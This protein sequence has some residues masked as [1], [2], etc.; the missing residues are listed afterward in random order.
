MSIMD[1]SKEL[2]KLLGGEKNIISLVHCATRLRFQL[3]DDDQADMEAINNLRFVLSV[4][5][6][7]GQF[8]V[9]IGPAVSK[10]YQAI[11]DQIDIKKS[12]EA[13]KKVKKGGLVDFVLRCISG[14]VTP[15]LPAICGSALIRAILSA[16]VNFGILGETDSTTM[17][18]TAAANAV[19][20][21]L[22]ILI[23]FTLSQQLKVNPYVGAVLGAAL[24]D[25]NFQGLIGQKGTTFLG[26]P[27]EAVDY[28]TSLLPI[29]IIIL[30]YAY[31]DKFLRKYIPDGVAMFAVPFFE[32]IILVPLGV[33]VFGPFGT[34]VSNYLAGGVSYLFN[35]NTA[36]AGGILGMLYQIMVLFGV[37]WG[38]APLCFDSLARTGL[39]PYEGTGG[40][41]SNFGCAGIA[42]GAYLK[43][44]KNSKM[45]AVS[46]SCLSSQLLAGVGEPTLYGIVLKHKRLIPTTMIAGGI[47]GFIAGLFN[48]AENAYVLHNVFSVAFMSYTPMHG[49]LISIITA[50][51]IATVLTYFW[52]IPEGEM[53]DYRAQ[54]ADLAVAEE[55]PVLD[56]NAQPSAFKSLAVYAPL[57]GEV[58]DLN[59]VE[60]DL[61]SN[62]IL[63]EGCAI[64]P[65]HN[66]I[67][68]PCDGKIVALYP[69]KH[70]IGIQ[71]ENGSEILIHIGLNT[72][73]NEGEGFKEFV[74]VG[75]QI[76]KGDKLIEFDKEKLENK[77]Y[78]LVTPIIVTNRD[79]YGKLTLTANGAVN[80]GDAIFGI[81]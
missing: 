28:G 66:V 13:N 2:I 58:I 29:F 59:D 67:T 69:S 10:Y 47:G 9:V 39:D 75:D 44:E 46:I 15:I 48:T 45:K 62:R 41:A 57:K 21:F 26:I 30:I 38:L 54:T 77:G 19:F 60:D 37:H 20:Y 11:N 33:I 63:G 16:L 35:L 31:F 50:F 70:A 71:A 72:V 7:G 65:H 34:T 51:T 6:K 64:I 53:E 25:P 27:V 5:N 74:K 49:I 52:A 79:S 68:A 32:F 43:A 73:M 22:P 42:F 40:I 17:I 76:H 4:V 81:E 18:L 24:L 14:S 23:G 8:Q 1:E 3:N 12:K 55:L 61:F 36:I 78:D 56:G 80:N